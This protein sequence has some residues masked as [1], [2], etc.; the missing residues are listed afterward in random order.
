MR[1]SRKFHFGIRFFK[2][3]NYLGFWW[4]V[5][6]FTKERDRGWEIF[7]RLK[8]RRKFYFIPNAKYGKFLVE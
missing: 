3:R 5:S 2:N 1:L 8:L 6:T 7:F 4:L